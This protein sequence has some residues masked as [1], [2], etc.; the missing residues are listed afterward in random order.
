[1]TST[2]FLEVNEVTSS[3]KQLH[4]VTNGFDFTYARGS[5]GKRARQTQLVLLGPAGA[6]ARETTDI[7]GQVVSTQALLDLA[8]CNYA[9]APVE[10]SG[11]FTSVAGLQKR[12]GD[13]D[14]ALVPGC[15][16]MVVMELNVNLDMTELVKTASKK[17]GSRPSRTAPRQPW[18]RS[19]T[20]CELCANAD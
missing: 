12:L 20:L 17:L 14:W 3:A 16:G 5:N 6:R 8:V 2:S 10:W 11:L 4:E 7:L 9:P 15:V 13:G 18:W 19:R 1:M